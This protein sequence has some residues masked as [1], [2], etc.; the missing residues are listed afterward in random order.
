MIPKISVCVPVYNVQEYIGECAVSLFEQTLKEIE[1]VFV[2]DCSTDNSMDI[3]HRILQKYPERQESVTILKHPV[4]QGLGA[5]RNT[6]IE[7]LRNHS[8]SEYIIHCDSDDF[9]EKDMYEKMYRTAVNCQADLVYCDYNRIKQNRMEWTAIRKYGGQ[10]DTPDGLLNDFFSRQYIGSLWNK[11]VK[12]DI[13]MMDYSQVCL[14]HIS[15]REDILRLSFML[16]NCK[17]VA[18]CPGFLYNYRIRSNSYVRNFT[19]NL[20]S[21]LQSLEVMEI[22]HTHFTQVQYQNA[23]NTMR[24]HALYIAINIPGFPADKWKKMYP[25]VKKGIWSD[26]RYSLPFKFIFT[27]ARMNFPLAVKLYDLGKK[28]ARKLQRANFKSNS[29]RD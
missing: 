7:Y 9:I 21:Q 20:Q 3:L 15:Y 22:L 16:R 2:D 1:F 11:L 8:R 5:A 14:P 17:T 12:R 4:N 23:L 19:R 25:E 18:H 6:A 27:L 24:R 26:K 28:I 29:K 13:V 10:A